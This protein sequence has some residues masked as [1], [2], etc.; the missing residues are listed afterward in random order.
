MVAYPSYSLQRPGV[1]S[2]VQYPNRHMLIYPRRRRA[3]TILIPPGLH[4]L[5]NNLGAFVPSSLHITSDISPGT[6]VL[7]F[8]LLFPSV[9]SLIHHQE[10]L[11]QRLYLHRVALLSRNG[12]LNLRVSSANVPEGFPVEDDMQSPRRLVWGG[13]LVSTLDDIIAHLQVCR[14]ATIMTRLGFVSH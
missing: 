12:P 9:H 5:P 7:I 6:L 4:A 11:S 1:A 13:V 10:L 14:L 2:G 3:C 8:L